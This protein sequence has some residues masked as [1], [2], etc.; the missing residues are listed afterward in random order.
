[1]SNFGDINEMVGDQAFKEVDLMNT[2]L[3]AMVD[4]CVEVTK[5]A[6]AMNAAFGK[7]SG[8]GAK[9]QISEVEEMAKMNDTLARS[10]GDLAKQKALVAEQT[11]QQR[12]ENQLWAKETL[13]AIGSYDQLN[14]QLETAKLKYKAL[15]DA[16]RENTAEGKR[17]LAQMQQISDKLKELDAGMGDHRRKVGD[18]RGQLSELTAEIKK[19]TDQ[20]SKMTDQEKKSAAGQELKR[21]IDEL[22]YTYRDLNGSMNSSYTNA[23][24][25]QGQLF[26]LTQVFRELPG[27]TYSAQTGIL[28]LSNNLPILADNFKTVATA[29]NDATGKVNGTMGALKIFGASIFSFGNVFAIAIGLFTIFSKEIFDSIKGTKELDKELKDLSKTLGQEVGIYET[30]SRTL[31]SHTASYKEKMQAA[32]EIKELQPT[33]LKNYSEEE[34]AAGKA[35]KAID[36]IKDSVVALARAR[37]VQ[38]KVDEYTARQFELDAEKYNKQFE[39][40]ELYRKRRSQ[41]QII[42]LMTPGSDRVT[43]QIEIYNQINNKIED[44]KNAIR[45]INSEYNATGDAIDKLVAKIG[46]LKTVVP[47]GFDEKLKKEKKPKKEKEVNR[48]DDLKKE[49]ENEKKTWETHYNN[50]EVDYLNYQL[51]LLRIA[52]EYA[53]KRILVNDKLTDAEKQSKI[54][55][56]NSISNDQKDALN[57]LSE[58]G[59]AAAK[60]LADDVS[61]GVKEASENIKEHSKKMVFHLGEVGKVT[62]HLNTTLEEWADNLNKT[63]KKYET[64]VQNVSTTL[65]SVAE[66]I[67][68]S[69]ESKYE[70][71]IKYIDAEEKARL[72]SLDRIS[73]SEKQR[74]DARKK[75]ENDA[76][77]RRN[78]AHREEIRRLRQAA[79]LKKSAAIL[80]IALNTAIGVT[81]A[82]ARVKTDGPLAYGEAIA[83]GISGA[84]QLVAAASQPLPQYEDGRIGGPATMAVVSEKGEELVIEKSGKMWLTPKKQSTVFIPEDA[85]VIPADFTKQIQNAAYVSL[86]GQGVVTLDKYQT[87]LLEKA[88]E[89]INE[90]KGLRRDL[91]N[92]E[93]SSTY[94]NLS[95][96][97]AYKSASIS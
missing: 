14:A 75:I 85:D 95:G 18:Y 54:D 74:D 27:F 93:M 78:Q 31:K 46:N 76:E 51:A 58:L 15:T 52:K 61:K 62:I 83:I 20:F 35:S 26:G 49:Y 10:N 38:S 71:Q 8:G 4:K 86:A 41:K 45:D 44:A 36:N 64:S 22:S 34:I 9:S 82:L 29:T 28:G 1:M 47:D 16:G 23:Q 5:V 81:G 73:M 2:K 24:K 6:A 13:A 12:R 48:I 43:A 11:R 7:S 91:R 17:W 21:H 42:D 96:F 56:I 63:L 84:A 69:A 3:D 70:A 37:A 92:K 39:L 94:Y 88:E 60:V 55:F 67:T 79:V 32:K 66:I 87:A 40:S 53:I 80:E 89:Q 97:D 77:A 25:Y 90:T 30:L 50:G 33:L 57:G 65:K 72:D 59:K 68:N 19:L